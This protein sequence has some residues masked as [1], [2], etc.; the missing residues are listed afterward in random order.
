MGALS[1]KEDANKAVTY[2]S[3]DEIPEWDDVDDENDVLDEEGGDFDEFSSFLE[4]PNSSRVSPDQGT[5]PP[6][7]FGGTEA[8]QQ[9]S[10]TGQQKESCSLSSAAALSSAGRPRR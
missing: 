9:G 5:V 2:D 1:K 6:M 10:G 8:E 7:T 3:D 4:G